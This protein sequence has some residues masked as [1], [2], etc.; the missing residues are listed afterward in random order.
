MENICRV[1]PLLTNKPQ[2][3]HGKS[4]VI[5]DL[6][7]GTCYKKFYNYDYVDTRD[8]LEVLKRISNLELHNCC[9]ILEIVYDGNRV[10]G[11]TMP[12]YID[13]DISV[14]NSDS[15]YLITNYDNLVKDI[16]LL[17][18]NYIIVEDLK[19]HNVILTDDKIIIHDYDLYRIAGT[20][21]RNRLI[22]KTRFICMLSDLFYDD[23]HI[24]CDSI[25]SNL[26][27][28]R[29]YELIN[30]KTDGESIKKLLKGYNRPIDFIRR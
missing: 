2:F 20:P 24:H 17:S 15:Q 30:A 11:Y 14:L 22:N 5:Y 13:K 8:Q 10:L 9:K 28:S 6:L 25:D 1:E 7:D 4:A 27:T 19:E 12:K 26:F 16:N 3:D 18:D 29:M 21:E 23:K